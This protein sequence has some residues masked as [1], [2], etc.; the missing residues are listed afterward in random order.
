MIFFQNI[1]LNEELR[2]QIYVT[3]KKLNYAFVFR[4]KI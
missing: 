3:L 2:T 4:N 1:Y